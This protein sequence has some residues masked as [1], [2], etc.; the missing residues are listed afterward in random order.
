[1]PTVFRTFSNLE[2]P[3]NRGSLLMLYR[4]R[5]QIA[6]LSFFA[7]VLLGAGPVSAATVGWWRF[8]DDPGYLKDSANDLALTTSGDPQH[9]SLP[10]NGRGQGFID[11]TPLNPTAKAA[12]LDGNDSF[13]V[14]DAKLRNLQDFTAE[15]FVHIDTINSDG[16][17]DT[18]V[19]MW[20]TD[21]DDRK[22]RFELD[23]GTLRAPVAE[24]GDGVP[25][26]GVTSDLSVTEG[27]DWYVAVA[28]DISDAGEGG[29]VFYAKNLSSDGPLLVDD[30][31]TRTVTSLFTPAPGTP[32]EIGRA[33]SAHRDPDGLFD[34]VRVS[35]SQ[36]SQNELLIN[37]LRI[38][39]PASALLL[40]LFFLSTLQRRQV[41]AMKRQSRS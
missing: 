18:V 10:D 17:R 23:N 5:F 21:T 28:M 31:E 26:E 6:A 22:F 36:L 14:S 3:E 33:Q 32:F 40:A 38:P 30:D 4:T 15:A 35:D 8:E 1:M 27:Q 29:T 13:N 34:E 37:T 7:I 2:T 11:A 20:K 9:V 19:S 12:D 24:D 41:A 25:A 39:E 16:E